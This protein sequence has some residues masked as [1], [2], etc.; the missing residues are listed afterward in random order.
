VRELKAR[1][2]EIVRRVRETHESVVITYRGRAV[3]RMVPMPDADNEVAGHAVLAD[4]E[5]LAR[6]IADAWPLGV[7]ATEAVDDQRRRL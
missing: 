3:A 6:E 1:A 5:G 4:I 7:S 2:S